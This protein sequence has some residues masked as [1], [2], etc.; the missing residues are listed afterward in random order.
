MKKQYF[1]R[2]H[3]A[4]NITGRRFGVLPRITADFKMEKEDYDNLV[5]QVGKDGAAVLQ[6]K[7]DDLTEALNKKWD[8]VAKG[9]MTK[10]AW[11][12]FQSKEL[13]TLNDFITKYEDIIK[14]Q[15]EEINVLRAAAPAQRKVKSLEEFFQ[16]GVVKLDGE[17]KETKLLDRMKQVQRAGH[18]IIEIPASE[19]VKAGVVFNRKAASI[20]VVDTPGTVGGTDGSIVDMSPAAPNSPWL[21]GLGG[22]ALEMFDIIY[23]PNFILTRVAV[24]SSN[25]PLLAW[26]NEVE[27]AGT[28]DTDLSE[29]EEKPLIQHK[30]QVEFSKAKKAAA[31]MTMTEEFQDDV[32][33]LATKLR[34]LLNV[35]VIRAFDDQ[36]QSQVIA[37]AHPYEITGLDGKV[38]FTTLFD[39]CG[40]LL[41]QIG[42]YNFIPN[43]LALNTVTDWQMFMDK[44]A[45]GRYLNPPFLDRLNRYLVEA[46]KV[47]VGYGLAGDLL[48]Y[49]VDIYK[50]FVIRVGWVNNQFRENKFTVIGELRY[51]SYISTS[52]KKAIVY[53]QLNAVQQKITSGS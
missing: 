31:A 50:D 35:D 36:V 44:D 41:A 3:V 49:H 43:T 39:A 11:E 17:T 19:L 27:F 23:N 2:N 14:K 42:F 8:D 10:Q 34:N 37:A 5:A 25:Q 45:E 30:W 12:D 40:A 6:K 52:R 33:Q 13:K 15:G 28:V 21:P 1:Y 51:H 38:P 46:N 4:P 53:N 16:D 24:G 18:G 47:A 9:L 7:A 26:I 20:H 22:T 32:P 29:G 48:Q